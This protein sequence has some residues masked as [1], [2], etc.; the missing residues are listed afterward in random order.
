[1]VTPL[2]RSMLLNRSLACLSTQVI[3]DF[4]NVMKNDKTRRGQ[5]RFR[6]PS[7]SMAAG[8]H[9]RTIDGTHNFDV[10]PLDSCLPRKAIV[11]SRQVFE[12]S[13]G[14]QTMDFSSVVSTVS[15]TDYF[16]PS[17][18]N[19]GLPVA[20]MAMLHHAR[21]AGLSRHLG[22]AWSGFFCDW[23]HSLCFRVVEDGV[24]TLGWHLG[25]SHF[26]GSACIAWP[27]SVEPVVGHPEITLVR[28][29]A[30]AQPA[31]VAVMS[32]KGVEAFKVSWRSWAWQREQFPV[33]TAE[34]RAGIRLFQDGEAM[35]VCKLAAREGL[36]GHWKEHTRQVGGLPRSRGGTGIWPVR[37]GIRFEEALA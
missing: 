22:V 21:K 31:M 5:K 28:A 19:V 4:N 2:L 37:C 6:R 14:S 20:D 34:S 18:A 35:P 11:L 3:E 25:L 32:L 8:L 24:Q 17:A 10:V 36:V 12:P 16:S 30:I 33:L 15:K 1:M 27:V 13:P 29:M 9:S 23:S 26:D 7:T